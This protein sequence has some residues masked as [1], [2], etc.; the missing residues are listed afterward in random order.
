MSD[1]IKAVQNERGNT[2]GKFG[3]HMKATEEIMDSLKDVN[4]AKNGGY[5]YPP[6]FEVALFYMVSKL[7]RL[8]TSPTHEDSALDLASYSTL[9]LEEIRN[10]KND[11]Q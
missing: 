2:Y 3:D 11:Q 7:V 6:G 8:A 10:A 9:W 5:D 1:E 4:G